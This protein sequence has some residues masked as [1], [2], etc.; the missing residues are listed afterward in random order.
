MIVKIA[1]VNNNAVIPENFYDGDAG[2]DLCS[3][4]SGSI[5][6]GETKIVKTGISIEIPKGYGGFVLPRSGLA[7]KHGLTVVNSPGLIDSGYRGEVMVIMHKLNEDGD[8]PFIYDVGDR[9][10]QLIIQ[11]VENVKF[12]NVN[13]DELTNTERSEGGLGSSGK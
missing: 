7:A 12:I 4:E 10:A 13:H 6:A 8:S 11:K 3:V 9:I 1:A 2:F 5:N